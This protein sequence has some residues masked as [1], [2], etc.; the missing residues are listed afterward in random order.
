M[1]LS[2]PDSPNVASLSSLT[3]QFPGD[4]AGQPVGFL[5]L[6]PGG[7]EVGGAGEQQSWLR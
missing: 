6:L 2:P 5:C 4:A 3:E 7:Q 1:P